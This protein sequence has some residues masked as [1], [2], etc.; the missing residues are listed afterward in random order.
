MYTFE[1]NRVPGRPNDPFGGCSNVTRADLVANDTE[2]TPR[3]V[4]AREKGG[5]DERVLPFPSSRYFI[6]GYDG[7]AF[8]LSRAEKKR[9]ERER[10][11]NP[12]DD[13]NF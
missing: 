6:I 9:K 10:T 2:S 12:V 7:P 3:I 13:R 8:R 11:S 1:E 4:A 5:P